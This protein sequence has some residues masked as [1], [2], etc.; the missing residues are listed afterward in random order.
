MRLARAAGQF[1]APQLNSC[2]ITAINTRRHMAE[3]EPFFIESSTIG[4]FGASHIHQH[5]L[6][7][8][9]RAATVV[10]PYAQ[11]FLHLLIK[12]L[13]QNLARLDHRFT[14]L[15]GEFELKLLET[16]LYFL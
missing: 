2:L 7:T 16:C 5:L 1:V 6:K 11:L 8:V 13:K 15:A 9:A 4:Q 12:V 10:C 14:D 3:N